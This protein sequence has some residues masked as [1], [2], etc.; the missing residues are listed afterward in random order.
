MVLP[1]RDAHIPHINANIDLLIG[2][3]ASKLMEPWEL[4]S[5]PGE[6]PYAVKTLFGWVINGPLQGNIASN[7]RVV[8]DCEAEC[9]RGNPAPVLIQL[10]YF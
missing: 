8:F 5:S 6:G 2:M 4:I 9:P 1:W 10:A 3:N 7:L